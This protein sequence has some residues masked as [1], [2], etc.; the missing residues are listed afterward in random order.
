MGESQNVPTVTMKDQMKK[1]VIKGLLGFQSVLVFNVGREL[2][3]FDYLA[4]KAKSSAGTEKVS[5]ISFSM[6]ELADSLHL[7]PRCL[8]GWLHMGLVCGLFEVDESRERAAKT[9]PFVFELLVDKSGDFYAGTPIWMF[10]SPYLDH[11]LIPYLRTGQLIN[12]QDFPEEM[13]KGAAE[14]SARMGERMEELFGR[15]CRPLARSLQQGGAILEVGSGYGLHLAK[16]A[17]KYKNCRV[18][19]IDPD[20]R[21]CTAAQDLFGQGQWNNRVTIL[22]TTTADYLQTSPEPF[23][24]V[25]M[26]EVLHE[27]DPSEDYRISVL[28]DIY[29]LL[30]EGGAL[31]ISD[32][33]IPE[34]FSQNQGNVIFEVMHKWL[35][36][37]IGSR[38]YD[39]AGFKALVAATPFQ[40]AE[41]VSEG[42]TYFWVLKK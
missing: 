37:L 33:T 12:L 18:A 34:T 28:T 25:L 24:L 3:I 8:D 21:A 40:T 42:S 15:K 41:K 26:N 2:G 36:V 4:D 7:D 23:D 38:F 17:K 16:W 6:E 9:A 11:S 29:S 39:E 1:F 22:N 30:R 31:V 20:A 35:E 5:A 13:F 14:S 10:S 32:S 19:G 27:L